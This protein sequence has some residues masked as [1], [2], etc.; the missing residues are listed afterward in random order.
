[1]FGTLIGIFITSTAIVIGADSAASV[2]DGTVEYIRE[3]G[4]TCRTGPASVATIQGHYKIEFGPTGAVWLIDSFHEICESL[5]KKVVPLEKQAHMIMEKLQTQLNEQLSKIDQTH[6][7]KLFHKSPH[8]NYV[9]VS[10][11][12]KGDPTVVVQEL[13]LD[14]TE[15]GRWT[16]TV[17]AMPNLIPRKCGVRFHGEDWMA[18]YLLGDFYGPLPFS[19]SALDREA[20]VA[21]FRVAQTGGCLELT[22]EK[23]I[24][25]FDTA[26]RLTTK[27]G[28]K[29][30]MQG[31]HVGGR[32]DIWVIPVNGDAKYNPLSESTR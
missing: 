8:I 9:S 10:G 20:V 25:L 18:N 5:E 17:S 19:P 22:E 11:Y 29:K 3:P 28:H 14:R 31:G 16:T 4:K 6:V 27:Y 13:M 32:R 30:G 21:G 23:A 1:M 15:D 7:N 24:K 2:D 12:E 26:V